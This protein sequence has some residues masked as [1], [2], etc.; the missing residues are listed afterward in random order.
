MT[1]LVIVF[2]PQ[3]MSFTQ[4][5]R[6]IE[7]ALDELLGYYNTNRLRANPDKTQVTAFHLSNKT[8][9]ITSKIEHSRTREHHIN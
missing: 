3:Y 2:Y 5:E 7:E 9:D 1:F 8:N 4:I 6:T